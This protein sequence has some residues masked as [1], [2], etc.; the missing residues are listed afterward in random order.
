MT[1]QL[2]DSHMHLFARGYPGRYGP[3]FPRGGEIT[4]YER[5]RKVHR[6]ERA[7]VIGYEGHPWAVGNNRYIA[8]LAKNFS[9]ITPLAFCHPTTEPT[10]KRLRHWWNQGFAGI[11]IYAATQ[12]EARR[13]LTWND[14]TLEILNEKRALVSINAPAAIVATL[15]PFFDRLGET[16][17]LLSH[18]GLPG[19]LPDARKELKPILDLAVISHLGVK[20]SAAYACNAYPHPGLREVLGALRNRF[21]PSRLYWGSDFSPALDDVTFAQTIEAI[22]SPGDPNAKAIF[23]K[24]LLAAIRR[25]RA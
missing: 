18:L 2:S 7:L 6:I 16:R 5:L 19:T 1:T 17:I 9:W 11:S 12:A 15:R 13:L 20:F 4:I 8:R 22:N 25:V 3:L 14:P 24:N 21:G 10:P 23:S